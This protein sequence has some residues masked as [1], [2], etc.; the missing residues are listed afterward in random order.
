MGFL[1]PLHPLISLEIHKYYQNEQRF[2]VVYPIDNLLKILKKSKLFN[3]F[4]AKQCLITNK[5]SEIP[6]FLDPKTDN[7]LSNITFTE[8]GI[9]KVIRR[10]DSNK[11]QGHD[12]MSMSMLKI[13]EKSIIKP[14][15][16][17]YKKCFL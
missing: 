10:L 7:S 2:N 17:I 9:E 13:C 6:S 16:I 14:P 4:F 11:A 15:V 8:K 3:Y 5:G 12:I 1:M